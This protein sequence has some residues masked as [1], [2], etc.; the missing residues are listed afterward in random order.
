MW[1]FRGFFAFLPPKPRW[2]ARSL[3]GR[4]CCEWG[5]DEPEIPFQGHILDFL[6]LLGGLWC[7]APGGSSPA[8]HRAQ[9][10]VGCSGAPRAIL[11][12]RFGVGKKWSNKEYS[13]EMHKMSACRCRTFIFRTVAYCSLQRGHTGLSC[14]DFHIYM[15]MFMTCGSIDWDFRTQSISRAR[16]EWQTMGSHSRAE[17]SWSLTWLFI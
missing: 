9:G 8:L 14:P 2:F 16:P 5:W 4:W 3:F 15:F 13:A 1:L 7:P 6:L 12:R 10:A 11:F 17:G